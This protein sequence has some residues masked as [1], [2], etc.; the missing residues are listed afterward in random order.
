MKELS[1]IISHSIGGYSIANILSAILTLLVCLVVTVLFASGVIGSSETGK[2]VTAF[3][4]SA[5][6]IV[7]AYTVC[8]H[9][10]VLKNQRGKD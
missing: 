9:L 4:T 6:M 3:G 7:L 5:A 1:E 8:K 10:G 2:M